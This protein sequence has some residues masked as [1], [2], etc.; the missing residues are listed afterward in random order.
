MNFFVSESW[1]TAYLSFA[2][3]TYC[4]TTQQK[5][6]TDVHTQFSKLGVTFG[7]KNFMYCRVLLKT[8]FSKLKTIFARK[9]FSKIRSVSVAIA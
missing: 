7:K 1:V 8:S 9:S 3:F 6:L 4:G 2:K 5:F